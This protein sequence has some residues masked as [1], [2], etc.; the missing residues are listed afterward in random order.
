M[1]SS[2]LLC[3]S[4]TAAPPPAAEK[5]ATARWMV[6][7]L[8]WGAL[9]TISNRTD[10][11]TPGDA[12]GNPYSFADVA[13]VPYFYV[14][15]LDASITD[16]ASNPRGSFALSEA[17]LSLANGTSAIAACQI[18]GGGGLGDPENPPCARL[19]LTGKFVNVAAGSPEEKTSK[20]ALFARHPSFAHFPPGHS[21]YVVRLDLDG[22]WLIDAYGGAAIITPSDYFSAN[23]TARPAIAAAVVRPPTVV[24]GG[25]PPFI[26]KTK[27]ARWMTETLTWGVLSSVS[28][29]TQ[30]TTVGDA[31]GNPC[32]P[33]PPH[34]HR[35]PLICS[36][37]RTP[38]SPSPRFH[39]TPPWVGN[40][41]RTPRSQ[42]RLLSTLRACPTSSPPCSTPP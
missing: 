36:D 4:F 5:A 26:E 1:L 21:F 39:H 33:Q 41:L 22:L 3:P 12:F 27:T 20:A 25:P 10:G 37:W 14:S 35:A 11:S 38:H 15:D 8:T 6:S 31:F 24:A 32:E 42:I 34:V 18:G 16:L 13:G 7:N 19:V 28:T 9:S 40:D 30:G 29:R 23:V 2:L 17:S